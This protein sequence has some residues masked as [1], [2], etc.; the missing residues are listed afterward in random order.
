MQLHGDARSV[1]Q[2]ILALHRW[3]VHAALD[4][5]L[6]AVAALLLMF[7][8][9]EVPLRAAHN[10][11]RL[12]TEEPAFCVI[13]ALDHAIPAHFLVGHRTLAEKV[14]ISTLAGTQPLLAGSKQ[15]GSFLEIARQHAY[16]I[17]DNRQRLQRLTAC[18][19][20]RILADLADAPRGPR[21]DQEID[22][23]S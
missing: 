4:R 20:M 7:G 19:A 3:W 22:N 10:H 15:N 21:I 14:A 11:S 12:V 16:L 1:R 6:E 9:D 18:K 5:L 17:G 2:H 23:Q 8:S 13:D